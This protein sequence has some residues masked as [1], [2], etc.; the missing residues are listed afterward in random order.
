MK[1]PVASVGRRRI[2]RALWV[3]VADTSLRFAARDRSRVRT[4][5]AAPSNASTGTVYV[6]N[7]NLN[8]VTAIDTANS[9][10]TVVHG[11]PPAMNGPLGYRH[12]ARR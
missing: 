9:H 8:S 7:L 11:V 4:A 1:M 12:R 5:S 6:T 3:P 2:R 10:T